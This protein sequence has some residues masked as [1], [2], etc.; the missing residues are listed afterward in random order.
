[1]AYTLNGKPVDYEEIAPY[2]KAG[3]TTT[4]AKRTGGFLAAAAGPTSGTNPV[5]GSVPKLPTAS[6]TQQSVSDIINSVIPGFSDLTSQAGG[7]IRNL[8]NG[9]LSQE[10]QHNIRNSAAT[11]AAASGMPGNVGSGSL[12]GN[13]TLRD[14]GRT[15]EQQQQQGLSDLLS[16]LTGV[17][18]TAALTPAQV[19]DQGNAI[20]KYQAAPI[21]EYAVPYL[22]DQYKQTAS[23]GVNPAGGT[24]APTVSTN[25]ANNNP[26]TSRGGNSTQFI[27]PGSAESPY[28][29]IWG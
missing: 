24:R 20:A 12:Y 15:T 21:P 19:Q 23:Q 14:I 10:T 2:L 18:G 6:A 11:Q 8:M 1:M 29:N 28:K 27:M 13:R 25:W 3:S 16:L 26:W 9:Q 5:F 17:S 4:P 7:I 22:L